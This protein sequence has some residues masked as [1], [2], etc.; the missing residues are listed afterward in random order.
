MEPGNFKEFLANNSVLIARAYE[1]SGA[2]RWSLPREAFAEALC[3]SVT[4]SAGNPA[5]VIDSLRLPDLALAAACRAGIAPAW[6]H[7]VVEYRPV[8]YAAAR[9]IAR[10]DVLARDLADSLYADLYGLEVR[11]G[12]R[13]SLL[14]YF[15]GRSSL[16]TWLRAVLAQRHIDFLREARRTEPIDDRTDLPDPAS[17][18]PPDLD[19]QRYVG[20]V[21]IAVEKALGALDTRDRMRLGYYYR[22]GLK[23]KEIGRLMGESESG[24]S[25]HLDRT[26]RALRAEI[27]RVLAEEHRLSRDQIR[28][29]Y[30]YAAEALPL[31]LARILPEAG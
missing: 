29:C 10:D 1:R 3:A 11:Q 15:H 23:L 22:H 28:L 5:A 4:S 20:A 30:D 18:D 2:A 21:A 16:A 8:L 7:F 24:V 9:A 26:R 14:D 25:R 12:R 31:D 13:R 6:E 17:S 27:E 19:R